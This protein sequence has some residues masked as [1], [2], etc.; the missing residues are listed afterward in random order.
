[1]RHPVVA[2]RVVVLAPAAKPVVVDQAALPTR[3]IYE[4]ARV[5]VELS[6]VVL[7]A[8]DHDRDR[9]AAR[10]VL[11]QSVE[12]VVGARSQR[13]QSSSLHWHRYAAQG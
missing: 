1:M 7:A 2:H 6:V 8:A 3:T 9:Q 5:L 13:Q 4:L 11:L 10:P 12:P